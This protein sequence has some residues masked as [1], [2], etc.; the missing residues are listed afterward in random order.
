MPLQR[1]NSVVATD[2]DEHGRIRVVAELLYEPEMCVE[3]RR[4]RHVANVQYGLDALD[5]R[6]HRGIV[7]QRCRCYAKAEPPQAATRSGDRVATKQARSGVPACQLAFVC[8]VAAARY[9]RSR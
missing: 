5:L 8:F 9:H 4:S 1:E 3:T 2:N 7:A 6:R